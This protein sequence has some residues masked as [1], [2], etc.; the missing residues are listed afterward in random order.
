M[1]GV[2]HIFMLFY[3]FLS[4]LPILYINLAHDEH[5]YYNFIPVDNK[6]VLD[7]MKHRLYALFHNIFL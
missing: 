6:L 4:F 1:N 7:V 5:Y 3:H 2:W